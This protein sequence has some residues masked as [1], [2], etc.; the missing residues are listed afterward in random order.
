MPD[1]DLN[2]ALAESFLMAP[3]PVMVLAPS[4]RIVWLNQSLAEHLGRPP[5]PVDGLTADDLPDP[6]WGALL[7]PDHSRFE[8]I[9]NGPMPRYLARTRL[10]LSQ[11]G[12]EAHFFTDLTEQKRLWQ[13]AEALQDQVRFLETKDPETG[14]LNRNA[15]LQALDAQIT[16]SRR[17][18]NTLSVIKLSLG[19]LDASP[20]PHVSLRSITEEINH[21]LRWADQIGRLDDN[22]F[23]LILPETP[24]TEAYKLANRLISE[25]IDATAQAAGWTLRSAVTDWQRGDDSRRLLQRLTEPYP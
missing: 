2:S 25:S 15:I 18:G 21:R 17:Y 16:R 5:G 3:L 8:I 10:R 22:S 24:V 12:W 4:Q 11:A 6:S 9:G 1:S 20:R 7:D 19:A 23:L 14:L 13:E